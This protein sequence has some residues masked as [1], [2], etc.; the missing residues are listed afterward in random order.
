V[1]VARTTVVVLVALALLA[2]TACG[3]STPTTAP[4]TV[5]TDLRGRVTIEI[6]ARQ[7][8]FTPAAVIVDAGTKVTWRN[9]DPI[10]HNLK[11]SADALDFGGQF[12]IDS[13]SP[14]ATYSFTFTKAGTFPYACTI[15]AG[16]T[17]KI[18]VVAKA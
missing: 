10:L 13:F 4:V 12:G 15:H 2:V 3:S 16:M 6:D 17:G 5:P 14:G 8:Q 18:E 7:N 1:S 11:K 9:T